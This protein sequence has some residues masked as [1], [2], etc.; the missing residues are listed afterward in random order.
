MSLL[1][2][3]ELKFLYVALAVVVGFLV[4]VLVGAFLG[5]SGYS[6]VVRFLVGGA[7]G[8]VSFCSFLLLCYKIGGEV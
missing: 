3:K 4:F 8:V 1:S 2:D 6:K 7:S 5:L